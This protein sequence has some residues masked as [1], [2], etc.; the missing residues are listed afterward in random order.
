M[1][2][3]ETKLRQSL[4]AAKVQSGGQIGFGDGGAS[5]RQV[6]EPQTVMSPGYAESAEAVA[7]FAETIS[8]TRRG[9]AKPLP[10]VVVLC[11]PDGWFESNLAEQL[12]E[13][14][15]RVHEV[16]QALDVATLVAEEKAC[17]VV[18]DLHASTEETMIEIRRAAGLGCKLLLSTDWGKELIT[19][20]YGSIFADA[21]VPIRCS[22]PELLDVWKRLYYNERLC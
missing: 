14:N 3:D 12:R 5:Y 21:C 11:A 22:A 19:S 9:I 6:W 4:G 2:A 1:I 13:L 17:L 20:V 18:A 15:C 7:M 10:S 16:T 8:E